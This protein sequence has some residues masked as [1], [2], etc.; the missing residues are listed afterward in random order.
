[1]TALSIAGIF[2]A[3]LLL[4]IWIG[5]PMLMG[6]IAALRGD[7]PRPGASPNKTRVTVLLATREPWSAVEDRVANLLETEYPVDL[8]DVVIARDATSST[9]WPEP[10]PLDRRVSVVV[11]DPPGGKA[12]TL[13]AAARAASGE[14]LV[15]ADT[16]QRFDARTIPALVA[17]LDDLRFGAV[18]GALELGGSGALSPVHWYWRLEKWLRNSESQVHSSVG[19]TGAVYA[20]RRDLW[21]AVPPG[22][23][24]DDVFVPMTVVLGGH[25]VGFSYAARAWDIRTFESSAESKRKARTLTGIVQLLEILPD[26]LRSRNPI[27]AQFI[28][29]KLARLATPFLSVVVVAWWLVSATL[30]ALARPREAVVLTAVLALICIVVPAVRRVSISMVRWLLQMQVSILTALINGVRKNWSVWSAPK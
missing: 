29:H 21:P 16:A 27:R 10:L 13:N 8:L 19:V 22:T 26:V 2:A 11:G 5:Y 25:R 23:L 28:V 20:I 4:L 24:L 1:M 12:S 17:P 7:L 15:L 9:E 30:F 6:A 3:V 14:V 18:S